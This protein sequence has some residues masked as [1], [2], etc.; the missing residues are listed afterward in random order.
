MNQVLK[1][2]SQNAQVTT[3][4]GIGRLTLNNGTQKEQ[5]KMAW[6]AQAPNRLRLT[7][8]LSGHL[9][10][11]IAASGDWVSFVSHT[12]RHKRHSAVSTDPDLAPYIQIPMRLSQMIALLLGRVPVREADRAWVS[13]KNPD[14]ILAGKS[15][16]STLQSIEFNRQGQVSEYRLMDKEKHLIFG[17]RYK[18]YTPQ[19]GVLM[20]SAILIY[21]PSGRT[22]EIALPRII[23][24]APV[25][26]SMFRLTIPGS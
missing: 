8:L 21:D 9:F 11:T 6:A 1:A 17:I 10:E 16:F 14:L 26:E 25:K 20:P 3:S 7:L 15:F 18:D 12:G 5:F 4:K 2:R 23:P 24:N 19:K 22:I 13:E